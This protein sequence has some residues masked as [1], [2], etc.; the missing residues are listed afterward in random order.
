VQLADLKAPAIR[1][2]T[3]I[4]TAGSTDEAPLGGILGSILGES[5]AEQ[6][7]RIEEAKKGAN[8]LTGLVRHKKRPAPAV[9]EEAKA[10]PNG[11]ANGKR[12]LGD[13]GDAGLESN[14]KRVRIEDVP[15]EEA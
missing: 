13:E 9:T 4:G 6:Q 14:G 12:K 15:D 10:E 7:A 2:P 11:N 8:D 1:L 3:V 5:A